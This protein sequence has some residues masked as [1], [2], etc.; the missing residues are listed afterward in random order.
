MVKN[1]LMIV[2]SI[3]ISTSD[4]RKTGL[5]ILKTCQP[6]DFVDFHACQLRICDLKDVQGFDLEVMPF[7]VNKMQEVVR[8]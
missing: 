3:S 2:S 8:F 7:F 4:V 6:D 5:G 1:P